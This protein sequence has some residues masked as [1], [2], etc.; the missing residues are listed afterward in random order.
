MILNGDQPTYSQKSWWPQGKTTRHQVC[1]CHEKKDSSRYK[2]LPLRRNYCP[3]CGY[4]KDEKNNEKDYE[5]DPV[6]DPLKGK[7]ELG[8]VV[9]MVHDM[10][11]MYYD[12]R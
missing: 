3:E 5:W 2:S 10:R 6:D 8:D 7:P 9:E 12:E 11:G 4:W 1:N